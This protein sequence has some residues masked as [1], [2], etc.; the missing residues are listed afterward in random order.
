[1]GAY[2]PTVGR[3]GST[4]EKI[5]IR[6]IASQSLSDPSHGL[7]ASDKLDMVPTSRNWEFVPMLGST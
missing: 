7:V 3:N 5:G 1:M 2:P 4:S 6:S